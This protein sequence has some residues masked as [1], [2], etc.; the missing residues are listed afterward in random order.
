MST[1]SS[2][3]SN[4]AKTGSNI[5]NGQLGDL[6]LVEQ[7][8]YLTNLQQSD[9]RHRKGVKG[10]RK[11]ASNELPKIINSKQKQG[12]KNNE[13]HDTCDEK[14]Q[15]SRTLETKDDN[16]TD[17]SAENKDS[18]GKIWKYGIDWRRDPEFGKI[19]QTYET[20]KIIQIVFHVFFSTTS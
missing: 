2:D 19:F 5:R 15:G 20:L 13:T 14:L 17:N 10:K 12:N 1:R 6:E 3:S 11:Q 7:G 8:E 9:K 16:V 18:D 4:S